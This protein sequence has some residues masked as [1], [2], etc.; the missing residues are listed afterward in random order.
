MSNENNNPK[1]SPTPAQ[2]VV[3]Q[4]PPNRVERSDRPNIP[5]FPPDRIEKGE[6]PRNLNKSNS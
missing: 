3:P 2:V 6:K 1:P 4:F 5:S